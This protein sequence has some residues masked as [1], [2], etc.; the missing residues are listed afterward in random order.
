MMIVSCAKVVDEKT[1]LSQTAG[2][3]LYLIQ[4]SVPDLSKFDTGYIQSQKAE[5]NVFM[6]TLE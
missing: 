3:L 5:F 2:E 4:D 6:A 1:Q